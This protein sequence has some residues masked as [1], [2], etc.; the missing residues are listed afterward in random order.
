MA[1]P[2]HKRCCGELPLFDLCAYEEQPE[3]ALVSLLSLMSS[4]PARHSPAVAES[5]LG[6]LC[7]IADDERQAVA[8]RSCAERLIETWDHFADLCLPVGG[9]LAALH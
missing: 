1:C 4:F 5:I 6:H 8:V 3:L 7:L 9:D 2:D